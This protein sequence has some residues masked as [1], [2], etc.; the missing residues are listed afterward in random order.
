LAFHREG[1]ASSCRTG[2][3]HRSFSDGPAEGVR[4]R[5]IR[6]AQIIYLSA[7]KLLILWLPAWCSISTSFL[8]RKQMGGNKEKGRH[9]GDI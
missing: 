4:M 5:G 7:A 3:S 9:H 8:K 1:E 6:K 2:I